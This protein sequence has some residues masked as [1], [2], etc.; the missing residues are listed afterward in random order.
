MT[1]VINIKAR[2]NV[3][4]FFTVTRDASARW[5]VDVITQ[6]APFASAES[7]ITMNKIPDLAQI[8]FYKQLLKLK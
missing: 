6:R 2:N 1:K 3:E 8:A 4:Y 5:R 7:I